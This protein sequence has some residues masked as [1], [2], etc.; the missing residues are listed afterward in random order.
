MA[1]HSSILAWKIPRAQEPGGQRNL[2][3]YSLWSHKRVR[4]DWAHTHTHTHH[5]HDLITSQR[6]H[7]Q[8]HWALGFNMNFG[9]IQTF[10]LQ[11]AAHVYP[12]CR[13]AMCTCHRVSMPC[14]W[15]CEWFLYRLMPNLNPSDQL[16]KPWLL[17]ALPK[18][19]S[20][21]VGTDWN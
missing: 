1:F 15:T 6:S 12:T 20:L 11:Q 4:H 8:I 17:A 5:P 14:L 7:F 16:P 10:S 2:A 19:S 3:G 9:R 21:L 18:W 13:T